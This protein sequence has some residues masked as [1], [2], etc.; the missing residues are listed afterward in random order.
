MKITKTMTF[1]SILTMTIASLMMTVPFASAETMVS[2]PAGSSVRGC[3]DINKCYIPYE[4]KVAVGETV[5][6]SNDDTEPHTV[7][8]GS[9]AGGLSGEF[10]SSL[11]M[12]RTTFSH[13]FEKEGIFDYFCMVHPW[14][15]GVV[16]VVA[17]ATV[18]QEA[19][20][21]EP[22]VN[23]EAITVEPTVNQEAITVEP[24]VNQEAITVEPTVNQE[25]I[26]VEPTVTGILS[27]GTK[28]LAWTT[29]PTVG[30]KME[31]GIEFEGADHVNYD[32]KVT[33]NGNT[34]LEDIGTYHQD[35][36]GKYSTTPLDSSD[37][38]DI[39][40]VFQG[41]GIDEKAGPIGENVIFSNVI[42]EFGAIA[43]MILA[44]AI[45]SI[46]AISA[47]SR[48]SLMSRI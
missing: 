34:V 44:I 16:T 17:G 46:I 28:I 19:I 3:D 41:F 5:T 40:I 22:T 36:K 27:D 38:V 8:A 33:Q 42:P 45:I 2:V 48:L 7:T 18:N 32:I 39:T 1:F 15:D 6:W 26:T 11:F 30:E 23:Q 12:I 14:M 21:V 10:D 35:G 31:I 29:T 4:V 9:A 43:M 37:P 24:T 25:A 13:T 47:K 20:T